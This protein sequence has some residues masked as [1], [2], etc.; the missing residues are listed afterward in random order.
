MQAA[1]LAELGLTQVKE[2]ET[3]D[4]HLLAKAYNKC[5]PALEA[6]GKYV[7]CKPHPN[8]FY[9][10][11]PGVR[12]FR[13]ETKHIP[14]LVGSVFGEFTSFTP[15]P[16]DRSRMS[17]EE[18]E[19]AIRGMLGEEGA[20]EL[21]PLFREAYPERQLVDLLRLDFIFRAPEI[22]YLARRSRLNDCTWSYLFNMDQPI[23][24]GNTPWHCCDIPY[25]FHNIDLVEYPHGPQEEPGL[26]ERVQEL[27]FGS[28]M[29]F[30]RTG[31]P[32]GEGIPAWPSCREG[33]EPTLLIDGQPRIK[34]NFDHRLIGAQAKIMGPVMMR[35]M[36][37]LRE[38]A[39]H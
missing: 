29:N 22:D 39:Q 10:G 13:E 30:A 31:D 14:L 38:N 4:Y 34:R 12:G 15:A 6:A 2:L 25:F 11:E 32:N 24:G 3:V 35:M 23:D 37:Q 17:L 8:A 33:E 36:Q 21:I 26:S 28:L 18:Q 5:K 9:L 7:G 16:Y 19:A 27:L 1:L 20:R